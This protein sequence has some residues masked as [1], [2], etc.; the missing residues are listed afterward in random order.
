L[1]REVTSSQVALLPGVGYGVALPAGPITV[2]GLR[3]L[4]PHEAKAVTMMLRGEQIV[5]I[6][7]QALENTHTD[8]PARKVGGM[9]QV[10]GLEFSY[11][12]SKGKGGRVRECHVAGRPLERNQP[13]QVVTNSML[14]QGGHNY[15]TF[16][17]GRQQRELQSQFQLIK[18]RMNEV[19]KIQAPDSGR[20][21]QT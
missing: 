17:E 4:I 14:A 13:Y 15:R 21:R 16:I 11:E 1:L 7:E 20:I 9:I 8:D 5:E 6:L 10:S 12:L 19:G 18:Q 2:A 3:N